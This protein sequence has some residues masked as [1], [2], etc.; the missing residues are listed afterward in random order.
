MTK[1]S[2][3]RCPP[4]DARPISTPPP[5]LHPKHTTMAAPLSPKPQDAQHIKTVRPVRHKDLHSPP[6]HPTKRRQ[7]PSATTSAPHV[8]PT[9]IARPIHLTPIMSPKLNRGPGAP[10]SHPSS[11][12]RIRH[13]NPG[14]IVSQ[15]QQHNWELLS[16][17]MTRS[18]PDW[19]PTRA[20]YGI[21]PG[22]NKPTPT[23][24]PC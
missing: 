16:S 21:S 11:P 4:T 12:R 7:H 17:S 10:Q 6:H 8:T 23:F 2:V 9:S 5:L 1:T 22:S 13:P 24:N 20:P 18:H 14:T 3:L 15:Q 19:D